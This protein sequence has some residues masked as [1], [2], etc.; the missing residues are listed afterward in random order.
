[1]TIKEYIITLHNHEDLDSFYQDMETPGGN[2]YIPNRAVDVVNRRPISRNTHYWLTDQEA[3]QVRN[4]PRVWDVSLTPKELGITIEPTWTQTG[5]FTKTA[6]A[7][8]NDKN[9]GLLRTLLGSKITNW[10]GSGGY[11]DVA[12][13]TTTIN[14]PLSGKNVDVVVVDGFIRPNHAEFKTNAD[15]SGT[16]RINQ[17]NWFDYLSG[18]YQYTATNNY[19]ADHG[20]H[21]A[22]IAAGNTQGWARDA[23]IYNICL[24]DDDNDGF[25]DS[26]NPVNF[27]WYD[28]IRVWHNNKPVNPATGRKN[29]T[30]TTNSY[31]AWMDL[32]LTYM[33]TYGATII[34]RGVTYYGP[35]TTT[36]NGTKTWQQLGFHS[37]PYPRNGEYWVRF[38]PN[39]TS[40][41]ADLQDAIN[42]G[43][44]I[45]FSAGN[46]TRRQ[47][48]PGGLDWDN[49]V[50]ISGYYT[51]YINRHPYTGNL[52]GNL[53]KILN[54][55][56][57]EASRWERPVNITNRGAAVN[58]WAPGDG[59]VSAI[60]RLSPEGHAN[61][62]RGL[63]GDRI[64]SLSGTSM[65]GPQVTGVIATLLELKPSF[66]QS[67][68]K[69]YI[70]S[71]A[72]IGLIDESFATTGSYD[73]I[74]SLQGSQNLT[75]FAPQPT[76]SIS[77]TTTSASPGQTITYTITTTNVPDGS[78]IYLTEAGSAIASVFNDNTTQFTVTINS[79]S[80]T[81]T[82]T[83]S[84]SLN[85][86]YSSRLQLRTGGYNGTVQATALTV[87]LLKFYTLT[88]EN[89]TINNNSG[90]LNFTLPANSIDRN[91][92]VTV[93][94]GGY[95]LSFQL[96]NS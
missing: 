34:H 75:L 14:Y 18:D 91:Y 35:W 27:N 50:E 30:V 33:N 47:D 60:S 29:P 64:I 58:I 76:F 94:A 38:I 4:D 62:P 70:Q 11:P 16:S 59:I 95:L 61:D 32:S 53:D 36:G 69:N 81:L 52:S 28:H 80:G 72:K 93:E 71:Q 39:L 68:I 82:R 7:S 65:S 79:N 19:N 8:T 55:G 89:F 83:V 12:T 25:D 6:M 63:N 90:T 26:G 84:P 46:D 9:W 45:V 2:L 49:R 5:N 88:A 74:W 23:K 54:V 78:T 77:V 66:T 42:D 15:G 51:Y 48:V 43:I 92:N 67:E 73:D 44:I 13:Q 20:A 24:Y 41:W 3:E 1:M 22:G 86:S 56:N 21:V 40:M 87:Q 17:H 96:V 57:I 37:G 31:T 85:I 10:G